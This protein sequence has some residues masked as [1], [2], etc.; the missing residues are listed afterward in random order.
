MSLNASQFIRKRKNK[1]SLTELRVKDILVCVINSYQKIISEN[2]VFNYSDRGTYK[3]EDYL[4]SCLVDEFLQY[5]LQA[6]NS[7]TIE[8]SIA[9]T[10]TK[11]RYIGIDDKTHPDPI[12]IQIIDSALKSSLSV[13]DK[14]YFAIECKR[15]TSGS[16]TQYIKDTIKFSKR[17]YIKTRLPFE[18][19]IGYIEKIGLTHKTIK[20][21]INRKL[22]SNSEIETLKP[23]EH[24]SIKKG[25]DSSYMSEHRKLDK[26]I[27]SVFHLFLNYS[28]NILN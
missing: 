27:F 11:E 10:E 12:D 14:V 21:T 3:P 20:D 18:G 25:F 5:E 24:C 4:T 19:Q 1:I 26:S 9:N 16:V 13:H 23:L 8:Y 6:L 17:K 22:S 15:F 28:S 7:G 2:K